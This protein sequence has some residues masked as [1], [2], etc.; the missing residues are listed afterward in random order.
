MGPKSRSLQKVAEFMVMKN[1]PLHRDSIRRVE[2]QL[3]AAVDRG[4]DVQLH[5]HPQWI[6][7]RYEANKWELDFTEYSMADL[8]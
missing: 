8:P 7:G 4:H 6:N 2:E 3:T 1:S 5:F